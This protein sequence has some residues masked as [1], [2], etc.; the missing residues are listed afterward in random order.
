MTRTVQAYVLDRLERAPDRPAIAFLGARGD[1]AWLTL[2]EFASQASG[3]AAVLAAA[4]L[5]RGGVCVVV[6]SNGETSA[7]VVLACLM[8]GAVPLLIAPPSLQSEGAFSSLTRIIQGIVQKTRPHVIV[9][10]D[11]LRTTVELGAAAGGRSPVL[12]VQS[13]LGSHAADPASFASVGEADV[14]AMQL[15]S[16]TTGFPKICVWQQDRVIAALEGMAAAMRIT[17]DDTCLNWTPLYHDMG[18]VNNFLLCLTAGVPLGLMSPL[19]FVRS[20]ASWLRWLTMLRATVT[21]SPN[22]GY[23]LAAQRSRDEDLA[24]V[25]LSHVQAFWNAAERIH[26][27]TLVAFQKRFEPYGLRRD[28]LKTNFGCAENVGGATFTE[29]GRGFVFERLDRRAFLEQR[30]AVPADGLEAES[31]AVVIVGAGKGHPQLSVHVLGEDETPL[32]DGHIGEIAL[33]TPSRMNGYLDDADATKQAFV[34]PLLRTG[35]LGYLRGGELFW[36][37]RAQERINVRGVKMDPSDLEPILFGIPA[38][39]PGCFAAFGQDDAETGTQRIVLVAELRDAFHDAGDAVAEDIRERTFEALGVNVDEVV[40][41]REGTLTKTSSGKR[42]HR[43]VKDLY[44]TGR[45]A[46]HVLPQAGGDLSPQPQTN[47]G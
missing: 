15:T 16:G 43:F 20:P 2:Q 24:G 1:H 12:V 34:G 26:Y 35:D 28:A 9:L 39:R 30:R 29:T 42:R 31:Q 13:A 41:V 3:D 23:A 46:N 5:A 19:D 27:E 10:D 14:A 7:R 38:L 37:G 21:W 17:R 32:P 47:G 40:L 36:V 4:G 25:D 18:L 11:S 6:L 22:F 44:E 33:E 8:L 45:L